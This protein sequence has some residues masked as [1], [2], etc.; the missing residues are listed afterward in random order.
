ML[1]E[2]LADYIQ[3]HGG[4]IRKESAVLQ[5]DGEKR[6][7]HTKDET[8][9]YQKLIWAADQKTLYENLQGIRLSSVDQYREK[10]KVASSGD[11]ILTVYMGVDLH[12]PY[13]QEHGGAHSFYTPSLE[14]LSSLK[15]WIKARDAGVLDDWVKQYLERTTYEISCPALR[16]PALA[17]E[18]KTGLL[19]STLMDYNL[20]RDYEERGRYEEL[21][22]LCTKTILQIL[23][24]HHFPGLLDKVQFAFCS[25]PLTIQKETGN[26]QG[27]ITGWAF[28]G[29][30][31]AEHRFTKIKKAIDTPIPHVYQ[32]GQWTFSPAGLPVSILTGKVAAEAVVKELKTKRK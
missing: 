6:Q 7:V 23:S 28:T 18:G 31:P 1:T 19:L 15:P 14:G 22:S 27:A 17:P 26:A 12:P 2:K 29:E 24:Q 16:D 5:V 13:F 11:S 21:K 3:E 32:C 10:L 9:T 25:T 20:V 4:E 30:I 8:F